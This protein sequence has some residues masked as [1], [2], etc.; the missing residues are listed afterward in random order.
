[1][2]TLM[3]RID[4]TRTNLQNRSAEL[5]TQTRKASTSLLTQARDEARD[6]R[7]Y[8]LG[9][10]FALQRELRVLSSPAA[11]EQRALELTAEGLAAAKARID[12]RLI[13]L[14]AMQAAKKRVQAKKAR[15]SKRA[16]AAKK[17]AA[18]LAKPR[19]AA[20]KPAAPATKTRGSKRIEFPAPN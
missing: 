3:T 6:W 18:P 20:K 4:D 11:L 5:L 17:P 1:M 12:T 16:A 8:L 9:R 19:S 2:G 10:R 7:S 14:A 15:P 13:E